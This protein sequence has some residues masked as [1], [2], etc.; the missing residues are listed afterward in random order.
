MEGLM[1]CTI[2][3]PKKLYHPVLPFRFNKKLLFCICRT[4]VSEQNAGGGGG[5]EFRHH[6]DAERALTGTWVID[7]VL[8]AVKKEYRILEIHEIYQYRVT[9]YDRKTGEGGLFADYIDTF[10]KLKAEASGY[11]SWVRTPDDEDSYIRQ[12]QE[13]E[14]ILLNKA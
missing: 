3:S 4:C 12:F 14:G 10:L 11:P 1:E 2:V 7:E 13:S 8:L 5:G 9:H 6:T